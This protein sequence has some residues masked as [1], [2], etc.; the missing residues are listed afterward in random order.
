MKSI[1]K[2]A[3]VSVVVTVGTALPAMAQIDTGI[4]FTT[5]VPLYAGNADSRQH[6]KRSLSST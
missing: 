1:L 5:S 3:A 6:P 2:I 4:E